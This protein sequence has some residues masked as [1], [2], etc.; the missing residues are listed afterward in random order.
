MVPMQLATVGDGG[1]DGTL[2]LVAEDRASAVARPAGIATLQAALDDW[3]RAAVALRQVAAQ[4]A[5]GDVLGQP[6]DGVCLHAP[7][8]RAYQW[9]EASTY[10]PH[11]ERLRGARGMALPPDH[12]VAP[13][14]YNSGSDRFLGPEEPIPLIGE[15]VGLDIEATVAVIT[16]DVP[17]GTSAENALDH[18][19]LVVLVNDLTL[20]NLLPQEYAKA[21]GFYQSKPARSVAPIARTPDGLAGAWGGGILHATVSCSVN[22]QPLGELDSSQDCAF[23]FGRIIAH[24]TRTR[25]LAAG[26]IIGSGTVANRDSSN[27]FGCLAEKRASEITATGRTDTPWL[28][29]G[30][31]VR[32]EAFDAG[33]A[34]LFGAID[35][36]VAAATI[37]VDASVAA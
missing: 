12:G 25:S 24:M 4:L 18:V 2:L 21:A 23:D 20:R 5:A 1:R 36:R 22:G 15:D 28:A 30:D 37:A 16:D 13:V 26:T 31:R 7:L 27:G 32:I 3:P 19:R 10:F 35:Q 17:L 29:V 11:M 14:V 6:L 34:S 9:A 8:P 33:G